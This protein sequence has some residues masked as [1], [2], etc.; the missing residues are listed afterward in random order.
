M[1]SGNETA[2]ITGSAFYLQA[3]TVASGNHVCFISSVSEINDH[4]ILPPDST[5][6]ANQWGAFTW[7][8]FGEHKTRNK[9]RMLTVGWKLFQ[10]SLFRK[11]LALLPTN[12]M[13]LKGSTPAISLLV[14]LHT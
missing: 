9:R 3:E 7:A 10:E 6:A 2:F 13:A 4:D 8:T 1:G 11:I 5:R 14:G 12:T